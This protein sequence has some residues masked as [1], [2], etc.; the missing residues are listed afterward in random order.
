MMFTTGRSEAFL[1]ETIWLIRNSIFLYE[2]GY[3]EF[4][5]YSLRESYVIK[6]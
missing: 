4:A 6:R 2:G 3:F 1:V 5:F